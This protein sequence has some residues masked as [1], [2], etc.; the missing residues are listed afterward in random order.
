MCVDVFL[1]TLLVTSMYS[2]VKDSIE[3]H[4]CF[5]VFTTFSTPY[6]HFRLTLDPW[7]IIKRESEREKER[8]IVDHLLC[9]T[10]VHTI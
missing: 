2:Y 8:E 9:I 6:G 4:I 10:L 7:N 5:C 1:Y 3:S